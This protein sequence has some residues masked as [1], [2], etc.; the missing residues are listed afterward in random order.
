MGRFDERYTERQRRA[1]TNAHLSRDLGGYGL[2][3]GQV[4]KLAAAGELRDQDGVLEPF[5][6][7]ASYIYTLRRK[8]EQRRGGERVAKRVP[9][10]TEALQDLTRKLTVQLAVAMDRH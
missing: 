4:V 3:A 5:Q 2:S 7:K 1:I 9:A 8:E 6:A 10:P